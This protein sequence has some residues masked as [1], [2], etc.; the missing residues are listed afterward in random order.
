MTPGG[1]TGTSVID[2]PRRA[3]HTQIAQL[4]LENVSKSFDAVL[5]VDEVSVDFRGGEIHALLGENGAGKST[6]IRL[7]AGDHQ[8]DAGEI[9]LDGDSL[10]FAHPQEALDQGI[11]CVHQTPMFAPNLSVTE[12]LFLGHPYSQRRAGLI[13]WAAEH[14]E[15]RAAL[16]KVG[17]SLNPHRRLR[18]LAPHERQFVA[19][20][21]AL[22][23]EPG[24]MLIDEI[25]AALAEPE[26][27]MLY[28]LIR[29][30]RDRGVAV[31]YVTHR[32]EEVFAIA[33]R[34]TVLR[35]GRHIA[36]EP[37]EGLTER[38]LTELIVGRDIDELISE[39]QPS[40]SR[41]TSDS[42]LVARG[43][44]DGEETFG[45]SFDLR[46][47][48]VLGIAALAGSGRSRL[49]RLLFGAE[50]LRQGEMLLGGRRY[51]P[52]HPA[53]AIAS[54]VAMLTEDRHHDGF[55]KNLPVWKNIT[56]PWLRRFRRR[57]VL[58]LRAERASAAEQAD[59]FGVRMPSI[60]ASMSQLS[61]GNQQKVCLAKWVSESPRVL[62]LDDP[63]HGVDIRS[64]YEIYDLIRK[65]AAQGVGIIVASSEFEEL[66]ILCGRV[67]LLRAGRVMAEL[68]G[69]DVNEDMILSRLLSRTDPPTEG[70]GVV[71]SHASS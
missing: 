59:R 52:S 28:E 64:R 26:V 14:R 38:R 71:A 46:P 41:Q 66:E 60:D 19:L 3:D 53:D 70:H 39:P 58:H 61:G 68:G 44:G 20:A 7:M 5:A 24:V 27:R 67:L 21:R 32:L 54:G 63:T 37:V 23:H 6:L 36:T 62:I 35:D 57:G 9:R 30:V 15:A 11:A 45:I 34:A 33:E 43:I 29:Q 56:L 17:L 40:A 51:A 31:V 49:L 50:P 13:D 8:P 16:S 55:V 10:S 1:K 65:L 22:Q 42:I 69:A 12:N 47:G 48:E 25:T 2:E 4:E 18:D